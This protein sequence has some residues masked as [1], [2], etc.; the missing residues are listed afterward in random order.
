MR[1]SLT[2]ALAV[3]GSS[4]WLSP[5]F[6]Q[7]GKAY[8]FSREQMQCLIEN[9]VKYLDLPRAVV[10]FIPA[11]CPAVT[12]EEVA[13]LEVQNSGKSDEEVAGKP[14]P[15]TSRLVFRKKDLRCLFEKIEKSLED[16][17]VVDDSEGYD[18]AEAVSIVLDCDG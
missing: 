10:L 3:W 1:Y 6:G 5:A 12:R 7:S 16:V 18:V 2:V 14:F 15:G 17:T 11:F 13:R 8:E 9:Q 4:I